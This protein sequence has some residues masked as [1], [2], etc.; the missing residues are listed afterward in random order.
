MTNE[1]AK[2]YI[3]EWCPYDKREKIINALEQQPCDDCIS[4]EDTL[5]KFKN[6]YFDNETVI[7]CAELVLGGMPPVQ[8]QRPKGK[9]IENLKYDPDIDGRHWYCSA[10]HHEVDHIEYKYDNFCS[11]CGSYM[12]GEED[13]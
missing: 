6:T 10:C 7:R 2:D 8:P 12:R 3:R 11:N 5:K 13:E 4:R 1:E 9:W